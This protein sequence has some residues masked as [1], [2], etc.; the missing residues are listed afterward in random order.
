M[1]CRAVVYALA[2]LSEYL[3]PSVLCP[4][5][6]IAYSREPSIVLRQTKGR[7]RESDIVLIYCAQR[8]G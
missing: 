8:L 5:V 4:R 7:P 6:H 1:I 3:S 2:M